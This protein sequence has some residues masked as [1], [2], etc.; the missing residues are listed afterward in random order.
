MAELEAQAPSGHAPAFCPLAEAAGRRE[1]CAKARCPFYRVPGT[2]R[3]CAVREWSPAARRT[4]VVARWF[5]A[6]RAE[7]RRGQGKPV[8]RA[9]AL[10]GRGH[11]A[12]PHAG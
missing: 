10:H 7:I 6:R 8:T 3:A 12:S 5:A 1:L 2:L 4:P 11:R 9:D